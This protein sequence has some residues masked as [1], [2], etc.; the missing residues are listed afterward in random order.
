MN[1]FEHKKNIRKARKEVKRMKKVLTIVISFV[2]IIGG[3][4]L[5][6]TMS[7]VTMEGTVVNTCDG[8]YTIR[9]F[10]GHE[11]YFYADYKEYEI[12][13]TLECVVRVPIDGEKTPREWEILDT[14]EIR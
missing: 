9:L 7:K 10:N 12:G 2:I 8:E 6:N 1:K 3:Y 4:N 14:K 11:Y 5:L 13:D